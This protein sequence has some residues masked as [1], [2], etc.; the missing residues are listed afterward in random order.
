MYIYIHT[1]AKTHA[2]HSYSRI[3]PTHTTHKHITH[4][5]NTHTHN[6]HTHNTHTHNTHTTHT[7]NTHTP[8]RP[9]D[10]HHAPVLCGVFHS[11]RVVGE[12]RDV[13]PV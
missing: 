7:H 9:A 6:T 5:H 4:T 1:Q 13:E 10:A 11:H 12:G 8:P 3:T 2:T